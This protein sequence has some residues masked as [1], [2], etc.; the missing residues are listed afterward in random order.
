M[1][2]ITAVAVR[3]RPGVRTPLTPPWIS[4]VWLTVVAKRRCVAVNEDE[5]VK[6]ASSEGSGDSSMFSSALA[7]INSSP[8][9]VRSDHRDL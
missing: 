1:I 8:D 6:K 4:C 3:T 9:K 7:H 5:V 2:P